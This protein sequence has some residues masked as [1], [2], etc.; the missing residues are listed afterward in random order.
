MLNKHTTPFLRERVRE[1]FSLEEDQV[2]GHA[3]DIYILPK[4]EEQRE[5]LMVWL[6]EQGVVYHF[7][8]SDVEGQSWFGKRFFEI[9]FGALDEIIAKKSRGEVCGN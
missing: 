2:S 8:L 1:A 9:P 5:A 7:S 6:K 3:S 4:D